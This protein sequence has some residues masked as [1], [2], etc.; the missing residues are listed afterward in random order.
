MANESILVVDDVAVNLKLTDLLLRREGFRVHTSQDA[1]QALALLR[2]FQPDLMLVDIELPGMDGL[3][4]TRRIKQDPATQ[5]IVV[6]ALSAHAAAGDNAKAL[7]AGCDGYITKPVDSATL[8]SCVRDQ[9][10]RHAARHAAPAP[11]PVPPKPPVPA[12]QESEEDLETLQRRFLEEGVLQSQQMLESLSQNF[13]GAKTARICHQWVGA[14]GILGYLPISECARKVEEALSEPA[15]D[16]WRIRELL[17]D[18]VLSFHEPGKIKRPEIPQPVSEA[19]NGKPIALAGFPADEAEGICAALEAAGA[20]PRVFRTIDAPESPSVKDCNALMLAVSPETLQTPWLSADR[21]FNW[22]LPVILA[23]KREHIMALDA[24]FQSLACEFLIDGWQPEE[25][26]MRLSFALR[27]NPQTARSARSAA[28]VR[29]SSE[30]RPV[31][32]RPQVLIADDDA[33]VRSLV[34][35]TLQDYGIDCHVASN[36]TEALQM[37]REHEPHAALVDVNMPG[38]DGY[39]VLAAVRDENIPV[40]MILLTARRHENDIS[41]GFTLGA[42]DYIV[43]PFNSVEL[44]ARLKRL[45]RR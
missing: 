42:D 7:K 44:I 18:L 36:G 34:R 43:K 1:E 16:T 33:T 2:G 8:V 29:T 6:V 3:T 25:A 28:A 13:D 23:G 26:L 22:E 31:T 38:L 39:L 35:L 5:D 17:S 40:R 37:I 15:P 19:L 32:G 4:L 11:S 41:R 27:R 10:R 24:A 45:L 21:V 12:A 14:A 30:Y 20:R 9:L